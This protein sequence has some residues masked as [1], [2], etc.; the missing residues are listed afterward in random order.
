MFWEGAAIGFVL[1]APLGPIGILCLQRALIEGRLAGVVSV[2]GA[3]V[4]DGLY[5]LAAGWELALLNAFLVQHRGLLHPA[6][7]VVLAGVGLRLYFRR[8][9]EDSIGA[10]P[11]AGRTGRLRGAFFTSAAL[12]L[13]NPLPILVLSASFSA[14]HPSGGAFA[15][16]TSW[17]AGVFTGSALWAPLLVLGTHVLS[18][19]AARLPAVLISRLCGASLFAI[20]LG[21]ATAPW[22]GLLP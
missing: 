5:A 22:W 21:V 3:A 1:C 17:A 7:G 10:C 19:L 4:V 20:G 11:R 9:S 2:L 18:P 13:S 16:A 15:A 6:A 8:M 12:M 14:L